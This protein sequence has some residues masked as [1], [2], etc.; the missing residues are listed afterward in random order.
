M[1][2]GIDID[3]TIT[4][5]SIYLTK[6]VAQYF[7]LTEEYL[8]KNRIYYINLPENIKMREKEFES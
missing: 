3:D 7:D 6:Y 8:I 5:T 1:K 2:I 4:E